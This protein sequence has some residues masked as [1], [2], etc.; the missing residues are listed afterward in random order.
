MVDAISSPIATTQE[1]IQAVEN[2]RKDYNNA[3]KNNPKLAGQM[4]GELEGAISGAVITTVIGGTATNAVK[5]LHQTGKFSASKPV[6]IL[7]NDPSVL[8]IVKVTT[9]GN[10]SAIQ[11]TTG[12][13]MV[14][15]PQAALREQEKL[16]YPLSNNA[17][18]EIRETISNL[19]FVNNGF[20]PL[21]GH[22]NSQCFDGVYEKN[23]EIYIVEVKPYNGGVKLSPENP[24]TDL[25]A[26][27][28][29][30][31]IFN[32][33]NELEKMSNP[34]KKATATKILD[35]YY[36]GKPVNKIVMAIDGS[37]AIMINLGQVKKP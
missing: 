9:S 17:S 30:S 35:A 22:C 12:G 4:Y 37:R 19:Y 28:T 11:V 20:K 24:K 6:K 2:W 5:A 13:K 3:L 8:P 27:M 34:N 7:S 36:K 10:I 21:D 14:S 31:W 18:G 26:Q 1:Q 29:D 23:G 33:T 16:K 25:P 32:R 15:L